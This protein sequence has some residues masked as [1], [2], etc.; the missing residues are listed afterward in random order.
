M[1]QPCRQLLLVHAGLKLLQDVLERVL[2][3]LDFQPGLR[4]DGKPG[5]DLLQ[6][7]ACVLLGCLLRTQL[8][9]QQKELAIDQG[10]FRPGEF[11][12]GGSVVRDTQHALQQRHGG[13]PVFPHLTG[14]ALKLPQSVMQAVQCHELARGQHVALAFP[15]GHTG[16]ERR[17][18]AADY[19]LRRARGSGLFR[20]DHSQKLLLGPMHHHG[21]LGHQLIAAASALGGVELT[22]QEHGEQGRIRSIVLDREDQR[23][24]PGTAL[25]TIQLDLARGIAKALQELLNLFQAGGRASVVCRILRWLSARFGCR[26]V[27]GGRVR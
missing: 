9:G 8:H 19:S 12:Q 16:K 15:R 10:G 25:R 14:Y 23:C 7:R 24:H 17:L 27:G 13:R 6:R 20:H 4:V 5:N 21:K 2:L 1:D 3:L 22:R 18:Q 26:Y 11:S